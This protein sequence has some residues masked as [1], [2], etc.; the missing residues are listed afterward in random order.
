MAYWAAG[1]VAM[2][3]VAAALRLCGLVALSPLDAW[4]LFLVGL[5]LAVISLLLD[6]RVP[7]PYR[8]EEHHRDHPHP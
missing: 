2:A 1:F 4:A 8:P 3:V 7:V 5:I 6:S